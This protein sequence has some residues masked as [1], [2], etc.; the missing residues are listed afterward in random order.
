MPFDTHP[1]SLT[2]SSIHANA[3]TVSG[4]YGI[5]NAREWL[6]IGETNNIQEQLLGH[7]REVDTLL[8]GK[9]PT[10]FTF[11]I[12]EPSERICRQNRLVLEYEPFCNRRWKR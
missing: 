11:E 6:Y 2:L 3:P 8:M 7:L 9:Q 4:V 12:C 1:R 5:S 10:G